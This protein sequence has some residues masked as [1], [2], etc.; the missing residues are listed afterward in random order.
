M[1]EKG[2]Y[3]HRDAIER[4]K[5]LVVAHIG[6]KGRLESVDFKYMLDTTRKIAL[7]LLDHFDRVG[8]LRAWGIRGS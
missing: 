8:L 5:Q 1:V 6:E 4:A 2:M 3:F 7:P